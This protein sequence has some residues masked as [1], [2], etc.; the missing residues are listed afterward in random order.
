VRR[1]LTVPFGFI[2]DLL[3]GRT[4]LIRTDGMARYARFLLVTRGLTARDATDLLEKQQLR[5]LVPSAASLAT[6]KK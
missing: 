2:A 4:L 3:S 5:G 6:L 1:S